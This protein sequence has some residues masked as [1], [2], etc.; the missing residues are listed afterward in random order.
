MFSLT[1]APVNPADAPKAD[2]HLGGLDSLTFHFSHYG[3]RFGD[4]CLIRRPLPEYP[5]RALRA[6]Q[7]VS[8]E[9]AIWEGLAIAPVDA[10]ALSSYRAALQSARNGEY[11][12]PLTRSAF[13]VYLDGD[14]LIYIKERCS[15]DDTRGRFLL[16]AFPENAD[17]VPSDMRERG[18]AHESLNFDFPMRG[19]RFDGVCMAWRGL[20][21]Y[22]ISAIETGQWIPGGG[23]LWR[24]RVEF[25]QSDG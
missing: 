22:P 11:G 25:S 20:P 5:I 10:A 1:A 23:E 21:S 13:D 18:L 2:A 7:F 19:A 8:G 16:S 17:Y 15:E 12:E 24:E 6:G 4:K 9:G 14:T 3:V